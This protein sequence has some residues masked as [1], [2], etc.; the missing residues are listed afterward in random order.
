MSLFFACSDE[1]STA[2]DEYTVI[3]TPDHAEEEFQMKGLGVSPG[4]AMGQVYVDWKEQIE[5][6]KDYV[7]DAEGEVERFNLAVA[8]AAE[9]MRRMYADE[10]EIIDEDQA[11][12]DLYRV[13][14]GNGESQIL[15]Q[16]ELF[17][18]SNRWG[19]QLTVWR[20]DHGGGGSFYGFFTERRYQPVCPGEG[21]IE[22]F[23]EVGR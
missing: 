14:G 22:R 19:V 21:V 9:Q 3:L 10:R 12:P 7:D 1:I 2:D 6:E 4:I 18:G 23:S 16:V 13:H 8:T 5:I 11:G 20:G 17:R 15:A